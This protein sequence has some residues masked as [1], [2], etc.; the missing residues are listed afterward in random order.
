[1]LAVL[2]STTAKVRGNTNN[3]KKP[4]HLRRYFSGLCHILQQRVCHH[5]L[6]TTHKND[7]N[8]EYNNH[9]SQLALRQSHSW[10]GR[11]IIQV[12][13]IRSAN[14]ITCILHWTLHTAILK[15][16]SSLWAM[17]KHKQASPIT[18]FCRMLFSVVISCFSHVEVTDTARESEMG[19]MPWHI[20]NKTRALIIRRKR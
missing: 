18:S 3:P 16:Y 7:Q 19:F 10:I 8:Q 17:P 14:L 13:N 15:L 11:M 2:L 20:S 1:M 9:L 12:F 5:S 6:S 4:Q